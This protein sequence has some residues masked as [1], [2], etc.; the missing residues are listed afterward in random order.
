MMMIALMAMM[1]I[2][3]VSCGSDDD[4]ETTQTVEYKGSVKIVMEPKTIDLLDKS[5]IDLTPTA[6]ANQTVQYTYNGGMADIRTSEVEL[7]GVKQYGAPADEM[8]IG[9]INL[10]NVALIGDKQHFFPNSIIRGVKIVLGLGG[11]SNAKEYT[12]DVTIKETEDLVLSFSAAQ[13]MPNIVYRF[14]K[15]K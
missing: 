2:S 4:K 10:K 9:P 14:T 11:R 7:K 1:T 5:T 6:I 13:A 15:N 8:Y 3:F 12:V